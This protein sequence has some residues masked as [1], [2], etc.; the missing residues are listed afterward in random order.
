MIGL[1]VFRIGWW[2]KWSAA[3]PEEQYTDVIPSMCHVNGHIHP[4]IQVYPV[5][6]HKNE[7]IKRLQRNAYIKSCN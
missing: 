6:I 3:I 5:V 7:T 1:G 4:M 2:G